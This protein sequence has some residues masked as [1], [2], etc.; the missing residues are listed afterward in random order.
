[1]ENKF[2]L[3]KIELFSNLNIFLDE[4]NSPSINFVLK[5]KLIKRGANIIDTI[6][7]HK[8]KILNYYITTDINQDI[9][10]IKNFNL[11]TINER[12]CKE[13]YS[14]IETFGGQWSPTYKKGVT[15][16]ITLFN[17]V[18]IKDIDED[19]KIILPH[20]FEDC[21]K[22]KRRIPD[23]I[24]LHP[25]PSLLQFGTKYINQL[26]TKE[27]ALE[28]I[29]PSYPYLKDKKFYI[30][31]DIKKSNDYEKYGPL[32][33]KSGQTQISNIPIVTEFWL[34]DVLRKK[35]IIRPYSKLCYSFLEYLDLPKMENN[36]ITITNYHGQARKYIIQL[37]YALGAKFTSNMT[38]ENTHIICGECCGKKY[39]KAIEWNIEII[40]HIWLEESYRNRCVQAL[41]K[42][43]YTYYP[44]QLNSIVGDIYVE[45]NNHQHIVSL[46]QQGVTTTTSSSKEVNENYHESE[47]MSNQLSNVNNSIKSFDTNANSNIYTNNTSTSSPQII[48]T[49]RPVE[50]KNDLLK[51]P[52]SKNR[53]SKLND[54]ITISSD[55]SLKDNNKAILI[56]SDNQS[57]S[58]KMRKIKSLGGNFV[59]NINQCTH[60]LT[61]KIAKTEKFIIGIS[62][63]KYIINYQWLNSS[64]YAGR[65]LDESQF[66]LIDKLIEKEFSFSLKKTLNSS[67]H[68]KILENRGFIITPNVYPEGTLLNSLKVTDFIISS[69]QDKDLWSFYSSKGFKVYNAD[70]VLFGILRQE[71][72][73]K[74]KLLILA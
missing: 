42:P 67:K 22:L 4:S 65:M 56:Q 58:S 68:K 8:N 72:P 50:D 48:G 51:T 19:V 62:I 74:N 35:R 47:E 59:N 43:L 3:P 6:D 28:F 17:S 32:L 33:Q 12:D 34:Y 37:I 46:F 38:T 13:L 44:P 27:Q 60:L 73:I 16:I 55:S 23:K 63:C 11:V 9:K 18:K 5:E 61:K 66:P 20:W 2:K 30:D 54:I 40:N 71:L 36:I 24:Y 14:S 49:L 31:P 39:E 1:M 7:I 10:S 70:F 26:Y 41:T 45:W 57:A 69:P 52:L 53:K 25:N 21:V 15:H 64:Y 29:E